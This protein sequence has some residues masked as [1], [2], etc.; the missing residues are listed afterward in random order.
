[1]PGTEW[2]QHPARK[3]AYAKMNK[4]RRSS[5][6]KIEPGG[7]AQCSSGQ[8]LPLPS[9]KDVFQDTILDSLSAHIAILDER[10]LIIKT[11]RAW[12]A[13][14][15]S[16]QLRM[17]PDTLGIN[18]LALCDCAKGEAS[19][20]AHEAC[21]GI[22]SVLAGETDE[23]VMEYPCH[24]PDSK[25]WFNMRVTR[26]EEDGHVYAVVSHESITTL[27]LTEE[28]LR[29]REAEL[30]AKSSYLAD[31]NT[32]LRVLLKQ[33]EDDKVELEEQV[34]ANIK[35]SVLPYLEMLQRT[36]LTQ[37]QE[38]FLQTIDLHLQEIVSPFIRKLSSLHLG[39]TPTEIQ[40]ASLIRDGKTTKE[41]AEVLT[42]SVSAIEFHRHQIRKKLGITH[43]KANLRSHLLSFLP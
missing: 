36:H 31:A 29:R 11:N 9:A 17:R 3:S 8:P 4:A 18:Y 6:K 22:R 12:M 19:E 5:N 39:L 38:E 2:R 25:L 28:A 27:K 30:G 20:T 37:K 40:V 23:F 41:I 33:R 26:F 35:K 43:N 16:N 24:S 21:A 1:M 7:D 34:L 32:A 13:F 14:A 42:V 10:G 15:C